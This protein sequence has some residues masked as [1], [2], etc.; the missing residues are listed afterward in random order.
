MRH[1]G[2]EEHE[3]KNNVRK[4][5]TL[6]EDTREL[7]K[8]DMSELLVKA[9]AVVGSNFWTFV[10]DELQRS[11]GDEHTADPQACERRFRAI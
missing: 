3:L 9:V 5:R 7:E 10:A 6:A 11:C 8:A 1:E 2:S 4:K